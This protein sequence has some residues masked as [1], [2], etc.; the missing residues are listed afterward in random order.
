MASSKIG[1]D[2]GTT[3]S[4]ISY[5]ENGKPVA[6]KY[7]GQQESIPSFIAYEDDGYIDIGKAAR[8]AAASDPQ[9]ESYGNFK[10]DLP[11]TENFANNYSSKHTPITVTTDYLRQLLLSPENT[12]SFRCQQGEIEG[13]VVSVPE[14]WQRDISNRGRENLQSLI[15]HNLGLEKQLIQLVS[16]PVAAAAYYA[17]ETQRRHQQENQEPFQGNLL[18][19]DM[20]G[21]T[22]DV[23][24]CRVYGDKKVEVLYFDGEG[25]R[26]LESA[27]VAFDR[28]CVIQ[29]YKKQN[30]TEPDLNSQEFMNLLQSFESLKIDGHDRYTKKLK[31]Y[32]KSPS[33][34]AEKTLYSFS[35]G[36]TI[37]N[38]EVDEAFQPIAEGIRR[39]LERV[40]QWLATHQ[41]PCDRLFLVGGF[42]QFYL[43]QKTILDALKITEKDP[44]V[45]NDFNLIQS[46][47]AISYGACLIANGLVQPRETY[48]HTIGI[49]VGMMTASME[50]EETFIPIIEGGAN[51]DDLASLRFAD[52][53]PLEAFHD[54]PEVILGVVPQSKGQIF[55]KVLPDTVKLPRNVASEKWRVGMRVN[56]SQVAY[57]AIV[58]V[59]GKRK[60]EYELGNIIAQMFP[61]FVIRED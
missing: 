4:T 19:C 21:G 48:I 50:V 9:M 6:F 29:A 52:I 7:G 59:G 30:G 34:L 18:V 35:N 41:E 33:Y 60:V 16:E 42:C 46:A 32:C 39:V 40:N 14:I 13:L 8:Q 5:L 45:D 1:L 61:G 24:L 2:F 20:G 27:G 10:M 57:L 58:S 26:G 51:L 54:T 56:R 47:F 28:R 31:N 23:S 55:K 37:T 44:R 36:Y 25:D 22:F 11:L 53:P 12:Y 3:N 38:G 49:V 15:A 43:V 17:W